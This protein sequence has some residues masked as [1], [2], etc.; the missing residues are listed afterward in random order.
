MQWRSNVNGGWKML[1]LRILICALI[2]T[3]T[4]GAPPATAQAGMSK[5]TA[6]LLV[7]DL[8]EAGFAPQ[9]REQGGAY[10][11]VVLTDA[12]AAGTAAQVN[13]FATNRGVTARVLSVQFE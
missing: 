6:K 3:A 4:T 8:I 5:A 10:F 7:S 2:I 13:T 12:S 11:I 9:I 1:R